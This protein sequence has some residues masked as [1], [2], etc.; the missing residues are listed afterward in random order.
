MPL[1]VLN[2]YDLMMILNT[3]T[4]EVK[5][6]HR[7]KFSNLSNWKEEAYNRSTKYELFHIYFTQQLMIM[8]IFE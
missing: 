8:M 5:S 4:D 3:T 6:D 7:G 2:N 1:H